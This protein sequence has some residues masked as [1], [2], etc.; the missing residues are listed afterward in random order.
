[1]NA[2]GKVMLATPTLDGNVWA[3]YLNAYMQSIFAAIASG[4]EVQTNLMMGNSCISLARAIIAQ[5]FWDSDCDQLMCIDSDLCWEPRAFITLIESPH[6]ISSCLY[7]CRQPGQKKFTTRGVFDG[8]GEEM[9]HTRGVGAGFMCI[10]RSAL[11]KMRDAYPELKCRDKKRGR[12]MYTLYDPMVVN[13]EPLGEDFS[14]CERWCRLQ[15]RIYAYKDFDF[16]H[17]GTTIYE[18]NF[19][20]D[21]SEEI[22]Q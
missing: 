9:I 19:E 16:A 2:K 3:S 18:G 22:H 6:E 8:V 1:M 11:Q 10:K 20:K 5:D 13:S 7:P 17:Y 21:Y 15:E 12:W 14:F 4:W